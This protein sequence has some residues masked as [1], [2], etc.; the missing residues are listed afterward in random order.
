M[1]QIFKGRK[2]GRAGPGVGKI[3]HRAG[4]GCPAI[5]SA[6]TQGSRARFSGRAPLP[7]KT[8][9]A[10]ASASLLPA[11]YGSLACQPTP[12]CLGLR[13]RPLRYLYSLKNGSVSVRPPTRPRATR[14]ARLGSWASFAMSPV[15]QDWNSGHFHPQRCGKSPT[16]SGS[17]SPIAPALR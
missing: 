8:R 3:P 9:Q 14:P 15:R 17:P 10:P 2:C 16:P 7:P 11:K 12:P 5:R 13:F 6:D 4:R 1:N